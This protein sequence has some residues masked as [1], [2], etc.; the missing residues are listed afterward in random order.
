M[1]PTGAA[2]VNLIH[3]K[4]RIP[5]NLN[6]FKDL[7][8]EALMKFQLCY[9]NVKFIIIDAILMVGTWLIYLIDIRCRDIFPN[10]YESSGGINDYM[11]GDFQQLPPV[12]DAPLYHNKYSDLMSSNDSYVFKTFKKIVELSVFSSTKFRYRYRIFNNT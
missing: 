3:L 6:S 10:V 12:N 11:F 2:A 9:K 7:K 5:H 4:F 1:T 8:N